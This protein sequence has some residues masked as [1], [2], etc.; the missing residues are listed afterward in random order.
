MVETL[1]AFVVVLVLAVA[2]LTY[3]LH[4]MPRLR[5]RVIINLLGDGTD[6]FEG[7]LWT[8]RGGWLVLKDA[9]LLHRDEPPVLADGEVLIDRKQVK[10]L[11][12]L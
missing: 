11:Q 1:I 10:F 2:V 12:V 4:R 7:V 3:E 5:H 8:I 9:R 6:T